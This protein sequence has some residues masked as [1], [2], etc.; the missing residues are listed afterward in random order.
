MLLNII[1]Q[2]TLPLNS[3]DFIEFKNITFS[4]SKINRYW[5]N[6]K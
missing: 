5:I 2:H 3:T 4:Y 6:K 1:I